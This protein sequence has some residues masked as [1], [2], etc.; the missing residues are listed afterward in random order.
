MHDHHSMVARRSTYKGSYGKV[1]VDD[2]DSDEM[3]QCTLGAR[4]V[5]LVLLAHANQYDVAWPSQRRIAQVTG[6]S[7][8]TV[9]RGLKQLQE[10]G[11]ITKIPRDGR[12]LKYQLLRAPSRRENALTLVE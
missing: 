4:A 7:I 3:R 8:I 10:V 1:F 9:K 5:Y 6:L 12:R 11:L 2:I